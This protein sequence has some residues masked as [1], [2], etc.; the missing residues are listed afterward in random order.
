MLLKSKNI[1]LVILGVTALVCSRALFFFINDPEGPNLLVVTGM[2]AILY[3]LSLAAYVS[4]PSTTGLKKLFMA[5]FVQILL[6]GGFYF[7][8]N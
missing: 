4:N 3:V 8:L 6:V 5:I 7:L 2:A 1:S